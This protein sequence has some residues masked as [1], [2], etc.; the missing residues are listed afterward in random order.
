[1]SIIIVETL[2]ITPLT[3]DQPTETD[4][5]ILSCLAE[6][7]AQWRYSLLSQ[8]RQRMFCTFEAPD[9]EAVRTAYRRAGG[10]FNRLWVAHLLSPADH[11]APPDPDHFIV[12]DATL[13]SGPTP[14]QWDDLQ[15]Q[16]QS[17]YAEAE[18]EWVQGYLSS[19]GTRLIAELNA[20]APESLRAIHQAFNLPIQALWPAW[21]L[22]PEP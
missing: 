14:I 11:A 3:P 8:D 17:H 7:D 19:D 9:A 10:P 1:M 21:L 2:A 22:Q 4:Y 12:L 20:P 13:P 6:R 18:V 5:R 16:L 15:P